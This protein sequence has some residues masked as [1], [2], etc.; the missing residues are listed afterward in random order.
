MGMGF[1]RLQPR[2]DSAG[3]VSLFVLNDDGT[4]GHSVSLSSCESCGVVV[5]DEELHKKWHRL[6]SMG[7]G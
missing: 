7:F 2:A 3:Y 6:N 4:S 5:A 1:V